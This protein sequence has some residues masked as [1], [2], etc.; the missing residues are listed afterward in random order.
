MPRGRALEFGF[1]SSLANNL[2]L[3]VYEFCSSVTL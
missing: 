2:S 3:R 1:D